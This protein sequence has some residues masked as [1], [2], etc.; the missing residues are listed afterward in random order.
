MTEVNNKVNNEINNEVKE[1]EKVDVGIYCISDIHS[2][3]YQN[4]I[5]DL[6]TQ[7]K[8]NY[9][10]KNAKFCILAGD[11]GSVSSDKAIQ[12][13]KMVLQHYAQN[14][15]HVIFVAGNHEFYNSQFQ[16]DQVIEKLTELA[17]KFQNVYFLHRNSIVLENVQFIGA[18]LWSDINETAAS[19]IND[20]RYQ[21]FR[22]RTEYLA[23]FQKDLKF[24][25]QTLQNADPTSVIPKVEIPKVVI[26]HHLPT[27]Q[28]VHPRFARHPIGSA[29]A[30]NILSSLNLQNT[31]FFFCGH[32]HESMISSYK[33]MDKITRLIANPL[34]YPKE[35]R[36][37]VT[38]SKIWWLRKLLKK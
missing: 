5:E 6:L 34:G 26:T 7:L 16:Y 9:T 28:L 19:L 36:A 38:S 30:T 13:Y 27:D 33:T 22:N 37:T 8:N 10:P 18:T 3:F 24:L 15:P 25:K 32:T 29:F 14:Y 2:E 11:I 23:A 20:F 31:P 12:A 21:V 4:N 17:K 35:P 1:G